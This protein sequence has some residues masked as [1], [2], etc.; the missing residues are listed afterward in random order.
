MIAAALATPSYQESIRTA[1]LR[2][3]AQANDTSFIERVEGMLADFRAPAQ[4][5][6]A[7]A[8]R[9]STR[10]LDVLSRHLDDERP[11]VR[12]VTLQAFQFA[13]RPELAVARLRAV[14]D[15]LKHPDARKR[16]ASVLEQLGQRQP[17]E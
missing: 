14:Q 9:G 13:L 1:A 11:Y 5:L 2:A 12:R 16:A 6:A 4:V 17:G 15:K 7:L 3:I 8:N 10:A